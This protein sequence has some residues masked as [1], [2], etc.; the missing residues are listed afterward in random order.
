MARFQRAKNAY[1]NRRVYYA[2][3]RSYGSKAYA[4]SGLQISPAFIAGVATPFVTPMAGVS[5]AG[6]PE[7]AILAGSSVPIKG[8]GNIKGYCQG[9]VIGK[10][11]QSFVGNPLSGASGNGG[12]NV[13]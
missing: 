2:K 4:K 5:L 8:L 3:A 6:L 11:L 9:Y 12:V 7:T 10:V 1:A 13:I